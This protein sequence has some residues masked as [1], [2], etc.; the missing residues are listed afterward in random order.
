MVYLYAALGMVMLSGIMA[1]FEMGLSLTGQSLLPM[2][3]DPYFLKLR[4]APM[5]QLQMLD[6]DFLELLADENGID[7]SGLVED[8]GGL[9]NALDNISGYGWEPINAGP[10]EGGCQRSTLVDA[11]PGVSVSHLMIIDNYP[12]DN[13]PYKLFSCSRLADDGRLQCPYELE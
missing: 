12:G 8:N 9:C 3:S 13:D 5:S 1:I 11:V 4:E 10:F 6:S 7:F 2:Q